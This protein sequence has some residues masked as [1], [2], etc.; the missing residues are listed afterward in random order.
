M[1]P[2]ASKPP[3][4]PLY[5]PEFD[6]PEAGPDKRDVTNFLD[7]FFRP[8]RPRPEPKPTA[9]KKKTATGPSWRETQR[10][11]MPEFDQE[12]LKILIVDHCDGVGAYW[13]RAPA[14][15]MGGKEGD[16]DVDFL[17]V[18]FIRDGEMLAVHFSLDAWEAFNQLTEAAIL[19]KGFLPEMRFEGDK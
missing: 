3:D 13:T 5:V 15:L 19:S 14:E 10:T 11:P 16:P 18:T 4:E 7:N 1:T 8:N 9:T 17:V 12:K 6:K 2:D